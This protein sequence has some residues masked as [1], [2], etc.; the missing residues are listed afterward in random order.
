[1]AIN[2]LALRKLAAAAA[3][4]GGKSKKPAV[5]SKLQDKQPPEPSKGEAPSKGE[6]APEGAPAV[7]LNPFAAASAKAKE[8]LA[9]SK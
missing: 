1:M 8:R 5:K 2:I 3:A 7:A 4:K 9:A 6:G